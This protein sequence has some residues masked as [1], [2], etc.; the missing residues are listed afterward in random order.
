MYKLVTALGGIALLMLAG[1]QRGLPV[2]EADKAI[3]LRADDLKEFGY[4]LEDTKRFETFEKTRY[5]DGSFDITY[6]FETPDSEEENPLYLNV[7]ATFEMNPADALVSYGAMK[8]SMK[9]AMKAT[10]VEVR[11]L[12]G[13]V[14]FGDASELYL[15]E[16]DGNPLGNLFAVRKGPR[17]Y[18]LIM[19]G[20][21]FDDRETW[22]DVVGAKLGRFASHTPKK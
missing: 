18:T 5:F 10:G 8:T 20:M 7:T 3:L 6:E 22:K 4:G 15:L 13:P 17:V 21:Y 12:A 9:Y 11:E 14:E 16:K 2:D 19:S 1:C